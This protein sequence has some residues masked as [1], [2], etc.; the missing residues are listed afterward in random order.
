MLYL[1]FQF[2]FLLNIIILRIFKCREH[3]NFSLTVERVRQLEKNSLHGRVR[4]EQPDPYPTRRVG[5][6]NK[7]FQKVGSGRVENIQRSLVLVG[8]ENSDTTKYFLFSELIHS[9]DVVK[10]CNV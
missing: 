7:I 6:G 8:F 9:I 5:S 1:L 4:G 10:F 2:K 3:L